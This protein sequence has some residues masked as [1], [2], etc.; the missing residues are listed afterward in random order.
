MKTIKFS[1]LLFLATASLTFTSCSKDDDSNDAE[2]TSDTFI[3]FTA[4]GTDYDFEDIITAEGNN[5]TFNGNNGASLSDPGD[6]QISVWVP[7]SYDE[8]TH[9]IMDEFGADYTVSFTAEVMGFDFDFAE[10][11]SIVITKKTADYV[12]GTFTAT[13]VSSDDST[14]SISISKGSFRAV[15]IQ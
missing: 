1:L 2:K 12:E 5:I 7:K 8:G 13:V 9:T 10:E 3:R 15:T 14:K 4:E 11:G 6:M